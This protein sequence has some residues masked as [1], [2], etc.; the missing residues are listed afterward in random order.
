MNY[1][2]WN[3]FYITYSLSFYSKIT[4]YSI[5][6]SS[7]RLKMEYKDT[8]TLMKAEQEAQAQQQKEQK[9][10]AQQQMLRMLWIQQP[11][12]I[13]AQ[14]MPAPQQ[15]NPTQLSYNEAVLINQ[16][17]ALGKSGGLLVEAI[18]LPEI[19]WTSFT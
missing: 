6:L 12:Q 5:H 11:H 13:S 2:N 8:W 18:P 14:K 4:V 10:Q 3:L 1:K 16:A 19:T 7:T 15:T 17:L 9:A